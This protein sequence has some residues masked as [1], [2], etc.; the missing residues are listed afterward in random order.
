VGNSSWPS[1]PPPSGQPLVIIPNQFSNNIQVTVTLTLS[2]QGNG[3]PY[4]LTFNS[5]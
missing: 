2:G 4:M 3:S 5:N 1:A